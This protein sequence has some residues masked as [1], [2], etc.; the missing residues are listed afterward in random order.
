MGAA[1]NLIGFSGLLLSTHP[2]LRSIG[3]LAVVGISATLAAT[4]VFFPAMLQ[5]VEDRG[6]FDG[7]RGRRRYD[8]GD[9]EAIRNPRFRLRVEASEEDE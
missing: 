8:L 5:I 1:T 2:G 3:I 7:R 9:P 6:W 4:L